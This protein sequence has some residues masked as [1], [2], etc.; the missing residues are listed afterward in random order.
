L[1][2][3]TPDDFDRLYDDNLRQPRYRTLDGRIVTVQSFNLK[4]PDGERCAVTDI[5]T[6]EQLLVQEFHLT[7]DDASD[8]RV[9][10]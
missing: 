3:L 1:A 6:G 8:E 7:P 9:S 4:T 5:N 10:I 2:Q